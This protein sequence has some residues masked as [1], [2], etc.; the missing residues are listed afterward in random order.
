MA[1]AW[2]LLPA[3]LVAGCSPVPK[4]AAVVPPKLEMGWQRFSNSDVSIDLPTGWLAFDLNL[5]TKELER[6]VARFDPAYASRLAGDVGKAIKASSFT[7]FAIDASGPPKMQKDADRL[8][9]SGSDGAPRGLRAAADFVISSLTATLQ[10]AGAVRR[11][12]IA[13]PVGKAVEFFVSG[14]A[15]DPNGQSARLS[16]QGYVLLNGSEGITATFQT[17]ASSPAKEARFRKAMETFR[18]MP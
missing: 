13:L 3:V 17:N 4:L 12:E 6:F 15:E 1:R 16:I 9:L 2:I 14:V 11:S 8:I 7:V 10:Q 5:G 18:A